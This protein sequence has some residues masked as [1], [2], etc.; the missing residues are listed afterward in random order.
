L[1]SVDG[2]GPEKGNKRK[3][4]AKKKK[5]R[6]QEGTEG[7]R[8]KKKGVRKGWKREGE[9]GIVG[10]FTAVKTSYLK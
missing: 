9:Y 6:E 1:G 2:K 4:A 5:D 7:N 3:G 8:R 10:H